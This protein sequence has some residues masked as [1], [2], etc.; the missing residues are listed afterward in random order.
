MKFF[1]KII[2]IS[3]LCITSTNALAEKNAL[4]LEMVHDPFQGLESVM[5]KENVAKARSMQGEE[6][7]TVSYR[8]C[9]QNISNSKESLKEEA[10]YREEERAEGGEFND[11]KSVTLID[12]CPLPA[13][14]KCDK[15]SR[16]EYF[17]TDSSKL[18]EDQK[19]GCEYFKKKWTSFDAT[20]DDAKATK[21][22][23]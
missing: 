22:A 2:S 19:E 21:A 5:G 10:A 16:I 23:E 3:L 14:G 9:I 15:G 11:T 17:Y 18:L 12:E 20:N 13:N 7:K 1:I 8:H 6:G 4:I